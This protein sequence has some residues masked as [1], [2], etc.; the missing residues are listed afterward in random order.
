MVAPSVKSWTYQPGRVPTRSVSVNIGNKSAPFSPAWVDLS[1][2]NL[3]AITAPP[4]RE[5]NGQFCWCWRLWL[6]MWRHQ[7]HTER[8][9][10]VAAR[11]KRYQRLYQHIKAGIREY[12]CWR[13]GREFELHKDGELLFETPHPSVFWG[14]H[15]ADIGEYGLYGF[16]VGNGDEYCESYCRSDKTFKTEG[17]LALG[18]SDDG[19]E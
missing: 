14:S 16:F 3:W 19:L 10:V 18:S 5:W 17:S 13:C 1:H 4:G 11:L 15:F 2:H 9:K 7:K 12:D 6:P 8:Q